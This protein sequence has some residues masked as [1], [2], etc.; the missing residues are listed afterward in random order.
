MDHDDDDYVCKNKKAKGGKTCVIKRNIMFENF[1]NS[2]FNDKLVLKSQ[3]RFK[4]DHHVVYTEEVN[5]I[6]LSSNDDKR[7]RTFDKTAT[8][9]HRTNAFKVCSGSGK[10]NALLNLIIISPIFSNYICM[11]NIRMKLN[12]NF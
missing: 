1:I 6:V 8:Y 3:Q 11:L 7:L 10:R 9:P 5:K 12:I 2:L 4:S